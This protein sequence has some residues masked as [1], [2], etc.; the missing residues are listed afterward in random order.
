MFTKANFR[1]IQTIILFIILLA[2]NSY[3]QMSKTEVMRILQLEGW[4]LTS[5]F[6]AQVDNIY[7]RYLDRISYKSE[8]LI[9]GLGYSIL[10]G[11]CLGTYES[12]TFGYDN[13]E[14]MPGFLKNWYQSS[15]RH[16]G[17]PMYNIFNIETITREADYLSDRSA[18]SEWKRF[19]RGQWYW[20]LLAHWVVKN[21]FATIIRDTFKHG[22]PFY[23]FKLDF[24]ISVNH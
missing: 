19:F 1:I 11:V 16:N 12:H 5:N 9:G 4:P 21:T 10:S 7:E 2:G 3:S 13:A 14:W 15:P 17:E 24:V 6:D 8:N 23:S 22:Q 18:Y 20:A